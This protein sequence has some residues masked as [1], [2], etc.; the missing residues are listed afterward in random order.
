MLLLAFALA[1]ALPAA[2]PPQHRRKARARVTRVT[3]IPARAAPRPRNLAVTV[4]ADPDKRYRLPLPSSEVTDAK[5]D[6]V[7]ST[8]MAC[9]T[10]GAPVCPHKGTQLLKSSID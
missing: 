8:G 7:R 3:N 10:T 5:R 6:A 4:P 9:G 2:E 1:N